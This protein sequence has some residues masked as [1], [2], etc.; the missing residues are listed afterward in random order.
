MLV[1]NFLCSLFR[2]CTILVLLVLSLCATK[3]SLNPSICIPAPFRYLSTLISYIY[4]RKNV[5][6]K[7]L[8]FVVNCWQKGLAYLLGSPVIKLLQLRHLAVGSISMLHC[9]HKLNYTG[10]KSFIPLIHCQ[11]VSAVQEMLLNA[12]RSPTFNSLSWASVGGCCVPLSAWGRQELHFQHTF[13]LFV[14]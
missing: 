7:G 11:R 1:W 12:L 9:S 6:T 3:K 14:F 5:G 8:I 2:P 10:N 4:W 13:F